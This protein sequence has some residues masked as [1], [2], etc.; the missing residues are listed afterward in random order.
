[1]KFYF[2]G[3]TLR[4]LEGLMMFE[5]LLHLLPSL[6]KLELTFVGPSG[7]LKLTTP[8]GVGML[9]LLHLYRPHQELEAV[10]RQIS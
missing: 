2:I 6:K 4:E 8:D 1:L 3:V 7:A 10:A 5:E 9:S